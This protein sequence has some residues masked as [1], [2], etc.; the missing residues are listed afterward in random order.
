MSQSADLRARAA[1]TVTAVLAKGRSLDDAQ[2][3]Q[4]QRLDTESQA[5]FSALTYGVL[6]HFRALQWL[7]DQLLN[8]PLGK[9]DAEA[10]G[11][12]LVGLYELWQMRTPQHAVVSETVNAMHK[13]RRPALR[14]LCNAVLRRFGREREALL[15]GLAGA[16][17]AIRFSHPD[18][19]CKRL[20]VDWPAQFPA[21]LAANNERA[22]MWLR[23]NRLRNTGDEYAQQLQDIGITA[24]RVVDVPEALLLEQPVSVERLP[25]F[26]DG[27]V[28]VQDLAPQLVGVMSGVRPGMRV[29]DACAAPGGKS[30]HLLE[31]GD[32]DLDLTAID[33]DDARLA[34][35]RETFDR[36]KLNGR[37][38]AADATDVD[39]WW[40]GQQFDLIVI[41]APCSATGVIRRHPDIKALRRDD[42]IAALAERQLTML[43]ALTP[44]LKEKGCLLYATCSVLKAENHDIIT[45]FVGERADI[46]LNNKLRGDNISGLM[47]PDPVGLQLLPGDAQADGFFV[48]MM[49]RTEPM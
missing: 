43:R 7:L 46:R 28:S 33:I 4:K 48:S 44:L 38:I 3:A 2:A 26:N 13:L 19:L 29:L 14:G 34:R 22:P 39:A 45:R 41:D 5:H 47:R 17:A 37:C 20:E 21:L 23:V 18:W 1:Q 8:K 36:L 24:S 30:A 32:N 9:K 31:L 11:L 25:G 42:D 12:L 40:D 16:P 15:D 27:L 35:V 6:R 49:Q 10:H